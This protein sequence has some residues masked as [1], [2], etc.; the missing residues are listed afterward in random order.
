MLRA[1]R[2]AVLVWKIRRDR[3][4]REALQAVRALTWRQRA[5]FAKGLAR[6]PRLPWRVRIAPLLLAA[7]IASP[8]DLL[9]DVIPLLGQV[10][11]LMVMG[12]VFKLLQGALPPGLVEEHL[13]HAAQ[14]RS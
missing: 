14:S 12:A 3:R 1:L 2:Y 10:D 13:Q 6:D 7:Y 11:D 8:V 4:V 9:P 5:V